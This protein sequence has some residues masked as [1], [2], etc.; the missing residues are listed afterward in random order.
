MAVWRLRSS[1]TSLGRVPLSV[2]RSSSTNRSALRSSP[3]S[4]G[5]CCPARRGR[6]RRGSAGC[7]PHRPREVGAA[8]P[9]ACGSSRCRSCDP[10]RPLEVGA[11]MA[12][13]CRPPPD[14][15][16]DPHRPLEVGAADAVV[17]TVAPA[18]GLR[19]SPTS[20]G[21]CCVDVVAAGGVVAEVA[22][23][24]DLSR[25]VLLSRTRSTPEAGTWLRSSP[26]SRGRCCDG[27]EGLLG[28]VAA[29]AILT[30]LE[31]S[32]LPIVY[33]PRT[34]LS[35]PLR[36]SPTSR[37]R[38][39]QGADPAVRMDGPVAILTDLERSVLSR[40]PEAAPVGVN[41][42]CCQL[43]E[44]A[45]ER[46]P[47]VVILTDSAGLVLLGECGRPHPSRRRGCNCSGVDAGTLGLVCGSVS[48][49]QSG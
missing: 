37:G 4:R 16:C 43:R 29:V 33:V 9:P 21:R 47:D 28:G 41:R 39:C 36:S 44:A 3:T 22:I 5:R 18:E 13:R 32:V 35:P 15:G 19:S 31:R 8:T 25:S 12:P 17:F 7:D 20:R 48:A 2:P 49:K 42:P 38:C 6:G 26:T 1:S 14:L 45:G 40:L 24:T 23:L 30:G 46:T 27:E 34:G 10:H 11:A